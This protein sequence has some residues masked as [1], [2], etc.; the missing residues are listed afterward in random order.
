M[1]EELIKLGFYK[2]KNYRKR[3]NRIS[4][5]SWFWGVSEILTIEKHHIGRFDE[6]ETF[7]PTLRC[8]NMV[9]V[10]DNKET[11]NLIVKLFGLTEKEEREM[12]KLEERNIHIFS[13]IGYD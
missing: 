1:D 4:S 8:N 2:D 13:D 9:V 3:K 6:G 7:Y 11:L 10:V 12:D 5:S